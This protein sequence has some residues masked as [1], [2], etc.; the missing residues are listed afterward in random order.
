ML[1]T[2]LG[3]TVKDAGRLKKKERKAGQE[4]ISSSKEG[5]DSVDRCVEDWVVH[6]S[7]SNQIRQS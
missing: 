1:Y 3:K 5:A 2:E 6:L 7:W 4:K